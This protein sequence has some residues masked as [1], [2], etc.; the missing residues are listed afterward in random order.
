[1]GLSPLCMYWQLDTPI[2]RSER[3]RREGTQVSLLKG[4]VHF[5]EK[6]GIEPVLVTMHNTEGYTLDDVELESDPGTTLGAAFFWMEE[7][8]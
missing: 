4:L 2:S 7:P 1:M 8:K 3:I 6:Y 5:R